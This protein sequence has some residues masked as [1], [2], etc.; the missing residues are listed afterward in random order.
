MFMECFGVGGWN[1][2]TGNMLI[3]GDCDEIVCEY[4]LLCKN[5]KEVVRMRS[6][7]LLYKCGLLCFSCLKFEFCRN[8]QKN[9]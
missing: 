9:E 6:N 4:M 8:Y 7:A 2:K 3:L 1:N 5:L